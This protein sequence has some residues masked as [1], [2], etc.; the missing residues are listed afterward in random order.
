MSTEYYS[1]TT[2]IFQALVSVY[3][4]F[5]LYFGSINVLIASLDYDDSELRYQDDAPQSPS[6]R[7]FAA[8]EQ[9]SQDN[10][11]KRVHDAVEALLDKHVIPI[12]ESIKRLLPEVVRSCQAQMFKDWAQLKSGSGS[13]TAQMA[14]SE[15]PEREHGVHQEDH[16]EPPLARPATWNESISNFYI[17]PE[18]ALTDDPFENFVQYGENVEGPSRPIGD[19]GYHSLRNSD[20]DPPKSP[21]S[22]A[23]LVAADDADTL[24]E[25]DLGDPE[26]ADSD[27]PA[28]FDW[29]E[30]LLD[31]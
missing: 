10:L 27:L 5:I 4:N 8:F 31:Q 25:E 6:S 18:P 23:P 14:M 7:E 17:E 12:E 29:G 20:I 16:S 2:S 3:Q 30:F 11:P 26:L 22:P 19:S 9:Y 1:Q 15:N 21:D 24:F 13:E 28:L